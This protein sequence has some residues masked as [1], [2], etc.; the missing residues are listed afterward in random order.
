MLILRKTSD[1]TKFETK[2]NKI[3]KFLEFMLRK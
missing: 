1:Q 2:T 3:F